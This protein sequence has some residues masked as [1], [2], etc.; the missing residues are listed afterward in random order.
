MKKNLF[1]TVA[2]ITVMLFI[3]SGCGVEHR[4]YHQNHHHSPEYNNRHQHHEPSAGVDLNIH[5]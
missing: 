1:N 3:L 5:N 2:F 4:Y